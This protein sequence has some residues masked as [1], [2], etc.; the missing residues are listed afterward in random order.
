MKNLIL[1]LLS[2]SAL[3]LFFILATATSQE[4]DFGAYKMKIETTTGG[5]IISN[6]DSFDYT[7]LIVSVNTLDT[8]KADSLVFKSF[9]TQNPI[10]IKINESDTLFF[11][12]LEAQPGEFAS[13]TLK[14]FSVN[15][16][17]SCPD[18]DFCG[19]SEHFN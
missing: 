7:N 1:N 16:D 17:G 8:L 2:F 10:S 15:V 3:A 5:I 9:S 13:D 14:R 18:H 6:E 12:D 11:S 4:E 19:F